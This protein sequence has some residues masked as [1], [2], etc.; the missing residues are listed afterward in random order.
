MSNT[1]EKE[2]TVKE[3]YEE[4]ISVIGSGNYKGYTRAN[5]YSLYV[6]DWFDV[7][8]AASQY[9]LNIMQ[10]AMAECGLLD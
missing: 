10:E 8:A 4:A 7:N 9:A 1:T 3:M 5:A 2:Y 6:D